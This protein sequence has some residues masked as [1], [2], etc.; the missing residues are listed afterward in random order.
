[1]FLFHTLT[2]LHQYYDKGLEDNEYVNL[3]T[4][5]ISCRN[6][7]CSSSR[8]GNDPEDCCTCERAGDV[9]IPATP[10]QIFT[11][12]TITQ[13]LLGPSSK[14]CYMIFLKM[15]RLH[16][17]SWNSAFM[18][19][20]G[21]SPYAQKL[22]IRHYCD[23]VESIASFHIVFKIHSNIVSAYHIP[24]APLWVLWPEVRNIFVPGC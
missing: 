1:M 7:R 16:S 3:R 19:P 10:S 8:N 24:D 15:L 11:S 17:R 2:H 13:L 12:C 6:V 20:E 5:E 22:A 9:M 14:I 21:S 23:P 18:E 4:S